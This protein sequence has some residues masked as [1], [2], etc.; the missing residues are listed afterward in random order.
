M[1]TK[2]LKFID[3]H[4]HYDD[5]TIDKLKFEFPEN[6]ISVAATVSYDSYKKYEAL[7]LEKINGLYF[8]Y[9]LYPDVV[10][11]NT[12]SAC[13]DQIENI[14]FDNAIAIGEIGIDYKI[15]KDK[16]K[17][18]EQELIFQKQLEIAEK[19]D[20]PVIIHSRYATKKILDIL[21]T[22]TH[23]KIILHWFSGLNEEIKIALDRGYYLT[24]RFA[25]PTIFNI[26]DHLDQIFIETDYPISFDGQEL[27]VSDIKK[28][29]EVFCKDYNLDF[30][31]VKEKVQS[32]F[33]KLF[34]TKNI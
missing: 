20:L 18:K 14:N 13:L 12:T 7:R 24:N 5:V 11:K 2:D 27:K 25:K 34:E 8:A 10:L 19:K 22:T 32:N 15:T 21:S 30:D 16:E 26:K 1:E 3:I 29:Y 4:C 33:L 28:S 23:K 6:Q 17:R 9:G 31:F